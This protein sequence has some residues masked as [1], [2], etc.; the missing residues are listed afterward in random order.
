MTSLV[1][2]DRDHISGLAP[3]DLMYDQSVP[4]IYFSSDMLI[5]PPEWSEAISNASE[6]MLENNGHF[7]RAKIAV[8]LQSIGVARAAHHVLAFF[9]QTVDQRPKPD[10]VD[11]N[12]VGPIF[13]RFPFFHLI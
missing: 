9:T 7:L 1:L 5:Q 12:E 2:S 10:I 4:S 8:Q 3:M 6:K 13:V 11:N